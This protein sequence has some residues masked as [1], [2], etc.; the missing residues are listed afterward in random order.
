M[1]DVLPAGT[2]ETLKELSASAG[3]PLLVFD[4]E[5]TTFMGR[6]NFGVMEISALRVD[7]GGPVM[8]STLLDP[9]QPIDPAVSE[10]TGLCYLDLRGKPY[11]T[12]AAGPAMTKA[13]RNYLVS[14]YNI[15]TFDCHAVI[16]ENAR[17]GMPK[18]VFRQVLD[19]RDVLRQLEKISKGKLVD[20]A[21]ALKVSQPSAHRAEA[22]VL[23]TAGVLA[24]LV[25]KHG[26][27]A[28]TGCIKAQ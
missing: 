10:L 25:R 9:G 20:I 5:T 4:L 19:V 14:G 22:D 16:R 11:W 13:A 12:E 28:V 18:P 1:R 24:A 23:M 8:F 15:R 27:Q 7:A 2:G 17:F 21:A 26:I 6:P 3:F